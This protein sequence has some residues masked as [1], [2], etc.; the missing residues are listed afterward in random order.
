MYAEYR[1]DATCSLLVIQGD[2]H[3][4]LIFGMAKRQGRGGQSQKRFARR[5][6]EESCLNHLKAV[7]ERMER[8]FLRRSS[9]L[10]ERIPDGPTAGVHDRRGPQRTPAAG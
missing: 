6:A 2:H 4:T 1:E 10:V 9:P 7:Y 5:L 3:N 8:A